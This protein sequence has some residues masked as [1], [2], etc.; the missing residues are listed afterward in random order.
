MAA[1]NA[2]GNELDLIGAKEYANYLGKK[3]W[4][5]EGEF[6]ISCP[7]DSV[8]IEIR[9]GP[10]T[11]PMTKILNPGD[12]IQEFRMKRWTNMAGKDYLSGDSHIH[13]LDPAT[14]LVQMR[15]EDLHVANLLTSDFTNDV[16]LFTGRL[17]ETSTDDHFIYVGQEIRDWQLGHANLLDLKF[18]VQPLDPFGGSLFSMGS[19]P[20]PALVAQVGS[21]A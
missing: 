21:I 17:D 9:R 12:E 6:S 3:R 16:E 8:F 7:Y 20:N 11:L 10:E 18:I 15:A 13:F 19:N 2:E 5:V 4:Y 1:W 14:A